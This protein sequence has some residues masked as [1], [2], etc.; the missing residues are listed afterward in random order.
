MRG[1]YQGYSLSRAIEMLWLEDGDHDL[2][3]RKSVSGFTAADHQK[4]V[5]A[6]V[7]EWTGRLRG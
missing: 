1:D 2:K 6:S 4:A 7:V 5:S 3:P